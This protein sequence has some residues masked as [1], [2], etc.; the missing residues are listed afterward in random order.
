MSTPV[1]PPN[2]IQLNNLVEPYLSAQPSGLAF[3]IGYATGTFQF[4]PSIYLAGSVQNQYNADLNLSDNTPFELGSLSKTFTATL[5]ALLGKKY[6]PNW[7]TKTIGEFAPKISVGA[8]FEPIPLLA[9]A[10]YTSG[11]PADDVSPPPIL[12]QPKYL[13]VPYSPAAMLGYLKGTSLKPAH[14]GKAYT[15]S[16]LAFSTLAQILPLFHGSAASE[17]LT[18]LMGEFVFGPLMMSNSAYFGD[19]YLD[20]LPVGYNYPG[21]ETAN[22]GN[23]VFPAYYGGGGI[24]STPSDLL[25]WLQFNMGMNTTSPLYP[26]LQKTQAPSTAITRPSDG[27]RLGLG[28]FISAPIG[29]GVTQVL[30]DGSLP[31]YG[32]YMVFVDW[33]ESGSPSSAGVFVLTNSNGLTGGSPAVAVSQYIAEAV[34]NIMLGI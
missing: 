23:V 26:I 28:W 15:Y 7:E 31:G 22:P 21:P 4:E 17:D 2:P 34:L 5:A 11:L 10:N 18:Q 33:I 6:R 30:K 1:I 16:N 19:I 13:P 32:S 8:Q 3:A 9:L 24:V 14:I 12:S 25:T 29:L 27:A 20:Q